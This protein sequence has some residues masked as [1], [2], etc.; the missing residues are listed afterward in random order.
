MEEG[1]LMH[2]EILIYPTVFAEH[3]DE[4]GHYFVVTSPNIPG[5]VTEGTTR[6]QAVTEAIDAI[7]TML[8]GEKYPSVQDPGQWILKKNETIVYVPV[9]MTQWYREKA[10]A[11]KMK[12]VRMSITVPEYLK[13]EAK[14]RGINVSR[15]ATQ[16]L[17]KLLA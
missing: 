1:I 14:E 3:H 11:L 15:V 2:D 10:L 6:Q 12:T 17:E 13:E 8:D 5:M 16:A 4:D 7:A 9:N